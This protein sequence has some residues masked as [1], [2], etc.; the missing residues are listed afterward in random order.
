MKKFLI[1]ALGAVFCLAF[2]MPA[3]AEVKVSGSITSDLYYHD[4]SGESAAGGVLQNAVN[5]DNGIDELQINPQKSKNYITFDYSNEDKTLSGR[6]RLRQG[7]FDIEKE[8]DLEYDRAWIKWQLNEQ[9]AL[10]FGRQP[11][12]WSAYSPDTVNIGGEHSGHHNHQ[13]AW[14]SEDGIKALIKF[15][16]MVGLDVMISDPDNDDAEAISGFDAEDA[17]GAAIREESVLPKFQIRLPISIGN[18]KIEPSAVWQKSEYDQVIGN[19]D[20]DVTQWGI[21]LGAKATFGP[22]PIIFIYFVNNLINN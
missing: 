21:A 1:V 12:L 16:D 18:I 7:D 14:G 17:T 2:T 22:V 3:M 13:P 19:D 20:D 9:V 5:T 8:D 10:Q 11:Q 15:N 4:V 6:I